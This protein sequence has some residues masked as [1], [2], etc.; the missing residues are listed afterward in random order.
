MTPQEIRNGVCEVLT[1]VAPEVDPA[2]LRGDRTLREQI[3]LDSVDV[4]AYV[5]GVSARFG[6]EIPEQDYPQLFRLDACVRYL[7]ARLRAS[8]P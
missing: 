2:T 4:M 8:R 1:A 6:I 5:S 7:A 3:D